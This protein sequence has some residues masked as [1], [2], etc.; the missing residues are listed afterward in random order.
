MVAI[1]EKVFISDNKIEEKASKLLANFES[2][3]GKITQLP[4]PIDRIIESYLELWIDWDEIPD[5]DQEKILGFLDPSN[6]KIRL[7]T[8]HLDHFEEY[9]GTE[10]YT[11]AHE[12]GHWDMHISKDGDDVQLAFPLFT[13]NN[14]S[15]LC[16]Q[17]RSDSREIQ[18]EKYA[19]FLL[20]PHYLLMPK[21]DGKDIT[22][23]PTLYSLKDE[24]GVTITAFKNRLVDLGLIYV[25]PNKK[26]FHSIAEY[27]GNKLFL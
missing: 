7:N 9:I 12:V 22:R 27:Q 25:S 10:A 1:K 2:Q 11:K 13:A 21:L 26:I 5:S 4:V 19:S 20:M 3:Y 17:N 8:R 24:F 16:R 6:K 23:W 18:A 14:Q 15:Y